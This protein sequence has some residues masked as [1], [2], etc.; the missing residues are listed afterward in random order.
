MGVGTRDQRPRGGA[1]AGQARRR[2]LGR[3][4]GDSELLT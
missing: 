1:R 2:R 4:C 3:D